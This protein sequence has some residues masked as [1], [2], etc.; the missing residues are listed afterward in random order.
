MSERAAVDR[1]ALFL[2]ATE[3]ASIEEWCRR[4]RVPFDEWPGQ[5]QC[6]MSLELAVGRALDALEGRA[7]SPKAALA[8]VCGSFGVNPAGFAKRRQRRRKK[9]ATNV[10]HAMLAR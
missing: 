7:L 10:R 2:Q 5:R 3:L 9:S 8:R 1:I 6:R 4:N